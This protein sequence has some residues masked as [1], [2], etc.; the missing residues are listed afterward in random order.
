MDYNGKLEFGSYVRLIFL[1]L[2]SLPCCKIG[3]V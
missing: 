2:P 3:M 1:Y